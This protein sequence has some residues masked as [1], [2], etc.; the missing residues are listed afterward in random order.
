ML[1]IIGNAGKVY[2]GNGDK[3]CMVLYSNVGNV[4]ED[5]LK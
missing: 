5:L 2:V 3:V 1:A 4:A